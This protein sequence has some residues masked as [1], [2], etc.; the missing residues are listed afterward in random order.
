MCISTSAV[1]HFD[2]K[3]QNSRWHR[4]PKDKLLTF[5]WQRAIEYLSRLVIVGMRDIKNWPTI[6]YRLKNTVIPVYRG[7]L[8]RHQ[9]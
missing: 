7:I 2:P 3:Y 5:P 9:S 8:W 4:C 6:I 1:K